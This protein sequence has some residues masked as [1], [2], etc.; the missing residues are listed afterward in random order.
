MISTGQVTF[1][2]VM[3]GQPGN[4]LK[5]LSRYHGHNTLHRALDLLM[6][7]FYC[8]QMAL[9]GKLSIRCLGA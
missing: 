9:T 5:S 2:Q 4:L 6:Q 3:F 8:V 1:G 7:A